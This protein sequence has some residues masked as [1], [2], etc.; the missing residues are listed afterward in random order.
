MKNIVAKI[1]LVVPHLLHCLCIIGFIVTLFFPAAS[2]YYDGWWDSYYV[3]LNFF[4]MLDVDAGVA[5]FGILTLLVTLLVLLLSVA[6]VILIFVKRAP[7]LGAVS[8]TAKPQKK[9]AT[10]ILSYIT[11]PLPILIPLN[12]LVTF[13]FLDE[14]TSHYVRD[15]AFFAYIPLGL[16]L[17]ISV[18]GII[19]NIIVGIKTTTVLPAAAPQAPNGPFN[20]TQANY[21]PVPNVQQP[22]AQPAYTAAPAADNQGTVFCPTCGAQVPA[23]TAFCPTC[24]GK[25]S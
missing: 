10:S 23:D 17:I 20:Y 16:M 18:I 11:L 2:Y 1:L 13:I 7:A 12:Y 3:T 15:E 21:T 6:S 19:L 25:I 5:I 24:G 8:K 4:E 9:R 14:N 22:V